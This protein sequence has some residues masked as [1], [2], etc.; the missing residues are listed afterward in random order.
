MIIIGR[1]N[2]L[3]KSYLAWFSSKINANFKLIKKSGYDWNNIEK[4][5]REFYFKC[6]TCEIRSS[7]PRKNYAVKHIESNY[8]R[9]R[10][11]EDKVYLT[12]YISND[13]K[14]LFTMVNHFTSY[15]G[16]F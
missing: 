5:T 4:D 6:P 12:Y 8:P 10:Y 2:N 7:K 14:Y 16:Q 9:Q 11:Q 3:L 13:T 15:D 1:R